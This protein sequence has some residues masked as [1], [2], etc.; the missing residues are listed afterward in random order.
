MIRAIMNKYKALPVPAKASFWFFL[1][2]TAKGIS[3]ITTPIF[4]RLLTMKEYG[5]FSVFNSWLGIIYI[6]ITMRL[7][8]GMNTRGVIKYSECKEGFSSGGSADFFE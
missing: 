6:V 5:N 1:F 2:R 8:N 7:T 3:T 4:T